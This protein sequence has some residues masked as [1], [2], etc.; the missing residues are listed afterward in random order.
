MLVVLPGCS[1]LQL[2]AAPTE[3][4][5]PTATST[6]TATPEPTATSTSTATAT[7]TVTATS[8]ATPDKTGTAE[9]KA[10][11]K[12]EDFLASIQPDLDEYDLTLDT[13]H[14]AWESDQHTIT[15]KSYG[16]ILYDE[17]KDV[18]QVS[19][20][21]MQSEIKW[22]SSS[23]LAG[24]GFIFRSDQN[25]EKG[26]QYQFAMMRLQAAPAWDVEYWNYGKWQY[27]ITLDGKLQFNNIINDEANSTNRIAILAKGDQFTIYINGKA[28]RTLTNN[29]LNEGSM[30]F[31]GWQESGKTTCEFNDTWLWVFD[32]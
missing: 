26:E 18:G 6:V 30:A 32:E 14:L 28:M 31:L 23:G 27:T 22:N 7:A 10:T 1:A 8:T 12:A 29:K 21:L 4:P 5:Q 24:C 25:F 20:F 19:D 13:G 9:A 17:F 3:T 2:A 11:K 15:M 16:D